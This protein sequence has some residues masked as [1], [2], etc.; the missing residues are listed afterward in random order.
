[1]AAQVGRDA[2]ELDADLLTTMATLGD[3]I[4]QAV[5]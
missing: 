3:E 2:D 4:G 5:K 1:V